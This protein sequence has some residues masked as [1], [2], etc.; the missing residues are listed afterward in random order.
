MP[1]EL[2]C[3]PFGTPENKTHL[4]ALRVRRSVVY[5]YRARATISSVLHLRLLSAYQI[6]W[7]IMRRLWFLYF[8]VALSALASFSSSAKTQAWCTA[9]NAGPQCYTNWCALSYG[10]LYYNWCGKPVQCTGPLGCTCITHVCFTPQC[11]MALHEP[12]LLLCLLLQSSPTSVSPVQ[13]N[14]LSMTGFGSPHGRTARRKRLPPRDQRPN[15]SVRGPAASPRWP[16]S[17]LPHP[18]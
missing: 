14:L 3:V 6:W 4:L 1:F 7:K 8:A 15:R 9:A 2:G 18:W 13:R 5:P 11:R 17:A 10:Q 16:R 12:G